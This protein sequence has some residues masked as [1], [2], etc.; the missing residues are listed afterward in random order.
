MKALNALLER[1]KNL[2]PP[3][4]SI[5]KAVVQAVKEVCGIDLSEKDVSVNG[6]TISISIRPAARGE[7]FQKSALIQEKLL[8]LLPQTARRPYRLL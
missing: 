1:F 3:D 5:R 6:Q 7:L 2:T 4:A 8:E